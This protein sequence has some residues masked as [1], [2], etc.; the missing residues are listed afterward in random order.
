M[1]NL[2]KQHPSAYKSLI[3]LN[4][5]ADEAVKQAGL[6]P[7]LGELVK[8]RV[9]QLNGC[10]FCLRM[11][12]RDAI[13]KGETSDRLAVVAAWWESQYFTDQEQ[14]ALG[15]AEEVTRLSVPARE[16]WDNGS[17]NDEQISAVSWLTVVMNAWNRVAIRSHYPVG[18]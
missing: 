6:D 10:A 8:I 5:E 2:S 15:L 18:P 14:A 7:L 11:H 3:A 12:T 9:S 17:L 13:A 4:G 1:V 16:D